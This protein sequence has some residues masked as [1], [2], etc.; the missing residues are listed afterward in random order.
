MKWSNII[1]SEAKNIISP[2]AMHHLTYKQFSIIIIAERKWIVI[3][4]STNNGFE[5]K[6][7]SLFLKIGVCAAFM[8]CVGLHFFIPVLM[9]FEGSIGDFAVSAFICL[10]LGVVFCGA[11]I[12]FYRYSKKV[13]IDDDGVS[14]NSMFGKH[15]LDWN[16]I[17]DYGLSYDGR[18]KDGVG[19]SNSYII[20]FAKEPQKNKNQYKKKLSKNAF[21]INIMA[22][23]YAHFSECVIPFCMSKTDVQPFI[24]QDKPHFFWCFKQFWLGVL[25]AVLTCIYTPFYCSFA[26]MIYRNKLR[27]IYKAYA[28]IYMRKCDIINSPI[29]KNLWG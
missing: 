20:Y 2:Q 25:F 5:L 3:I 11:L 13:V 24:P 21:K 12:S 6:S 18:S 27:M 14:Y 23:D 7:T 26:M 29:N 8:E 17:Q 4:K 10:W 15:Y 28:L 1:L 9:E 22:D 19:Y 16:E